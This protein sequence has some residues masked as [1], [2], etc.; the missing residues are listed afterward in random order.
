MGTNQGLNDG[1]TGSY[2][3]KRKEC[4]VSGYITEDADGLR[5]CGVGGGLCSGHSCLSKKYWNKDHHQP[6]WYK[7]RALE[8]TGLGEAY[9]EEMG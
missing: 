1:A 7:N 5:T 6:G 3:R 2:E 9:E 8:R 4:E